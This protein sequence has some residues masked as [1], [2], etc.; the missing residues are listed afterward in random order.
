[1]TPPNKSTATNDIH[2]GS[3]TNDPDIAATTDIPPNIASSH[4]DTPAGS[5]T[6]SAYSHAY[7]YDVLRADKTDHRRR[8]GTD[9]DTNIPTPHPLW[10]SAD[11]A[12]AVEINI[13][14]FLHMTL[15]PLLSSDPE[16]PF[17]SFIAVS[18]VKL[19]HLISISVRLIILT[20]LTLSGRRIFRYPSC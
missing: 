3:T 8:T 19:P 2:P 18:L 14:E 6:D 11:I 9:D 15:A 1:L 17:E 20:E 13:K 12:K 16:K 10:Q 7:H 5:D 4:N